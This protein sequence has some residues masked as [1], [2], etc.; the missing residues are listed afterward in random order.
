[1]PAGH[2]TER[3][4]LE[5]GPHGGGVR[6][7]WAG[8]VSSVGLGLKVQARTVEADVPDHPA[9]V[10]DHEAVGAC[11]KEHVARPWRR[12]AGAISRQVGWE[13]AGGHSKDFA[14]VRPAYT[15][16]DQLQRVWRRGQEAEDRRHDLAV[17]WYGGRCDAVEH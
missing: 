7:G 3:I 4:E 9:G 6:R 10:V 15:V 17:R 16:G 13:R 5:Q 14:R 8:D 1:E 11:G 12:P 2:G